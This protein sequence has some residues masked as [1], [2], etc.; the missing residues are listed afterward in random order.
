MLAVLTTQSISST[1]L[2]CTKDHKGVSMPRQLWRQRGSPATGTKRAPFCA[3]TMSQGCGTQGD[4]R[5][6]YDTTLV[7]YG[8]CVDFKVGARTN[9][10]CLFLAVYICVPDH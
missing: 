2:G 1:P 8:H 9:S 3:V 10:A 4:G 5:V 6:P 7:P